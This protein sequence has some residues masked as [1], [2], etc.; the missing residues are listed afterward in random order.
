MIIGFS[1]KKGGGKDTISNM[2]FG[3]IEK[4]FG[5][6]SVQIYSLAS[7]LKSLCMA[8][9]AS[10]THVHGS[11]AQ[12][13]APTDILWE[14]MPYNDGR[15]GPI[16]GRELMEHLGTDVLRKINH[17]IWLNYLSLSSLNYEFTIVNDVRFINEADFILQN[18]GLVYRL[19][20]GE[21]GNHISNTNLDDYTKFTHIID[22]KNSSLKDLEI[23]AKEVF[24]EVVGKYEY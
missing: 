4:R 8:L 11:L 23:F 7:P 6:G 16:S 10:L 12:K 9:G 21:E 2:L 13:D 14:N 15:T 1:A 20:R 22:N 19:T 5:V 17:N 18:N 24:L 3:M